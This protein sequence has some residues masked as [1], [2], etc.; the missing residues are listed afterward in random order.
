MA[1]P[2][3]RLGFDIAPLSHAFETL[4][5]SERMYSAMN[6]EM[7]HV[8]QG[9]MCGSDEDRRWRRFFLGKVNP[10][11]RASGTLLYSYLTIPRYTAPRWYL[12]G[13]AVFIG[14][15]PGWVV[16]GRAQGR[17]ERDGLPG[18]GTGDAHFYDPLG[19]ISRGTRVDFQTGANAYLYGTRFFTYLAFTLFA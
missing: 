8:V 4:P 19:L 13:S 10:K 17:Y 14:G 3:S 1:A 15:A 9:D 5:A 2:H 12:E 16:V 6:H 7:V 18:H 11:A